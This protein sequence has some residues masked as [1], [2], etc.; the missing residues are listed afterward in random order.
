[1][2]QQ[3]SFLFMTEE[4]PT[5]WRDHILFALSRLVDIWVVSTFQLS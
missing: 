5:T 4:Y 2:S 3:E 1:M